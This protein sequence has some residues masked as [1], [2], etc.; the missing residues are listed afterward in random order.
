M[1]TKRLLLSLSIL[2]SFLLASAQVAE[3]DWPLEILSEGHGFTEGVSLA[4]DGSL[5]F[6]DMDKEK[7]LR[8]DPH[9]AETEVW[10]EKSGKTNGLYI[11]DSKLYGCEAVGRAVVQYDL[12]QGPGSRKVL[13]SD[14]QGKKLGCPN[15]LTLM[16]DMLYFSEFW[17]AGFHQETGEQREIFTNRVYAYHLKKHTLDSLKFSFKTPNGVASSPD[18][19]FLFIGD[20]EANKLYRAKVKKGQVGELEELVDL[21]KLELVGPDG[22]AIHRDGRIFLALYRSD[23]LLVLNPDGSA[24]GTLATGSLTSNCYFA[25]DGKTLYITADQKLKRVIVP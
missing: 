3:L 1:Y 2:A 5:F 16:G 11:H 25:A 8:F 14:F 23:K 15:D 10:Q 6:S 18:G 21:S 7:I 20:I 12:A 13:V 22:L 24:I 9:K 19:K 17:I 4:S